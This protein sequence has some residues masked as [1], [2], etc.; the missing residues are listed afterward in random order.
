MRCLAECP[1]GSVG[2]LSVILGCLHQ[3]SNGC[4]VV[5]MEG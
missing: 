3:P 2:L 1:V 4:A 5:E